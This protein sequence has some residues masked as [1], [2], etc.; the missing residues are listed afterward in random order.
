M[1]R[2]FSTA[3][4][5]DAAGRPGRS[6]GG[7]AALPWVFALGTIAAQI[8]YPLVDGDW[9]RRVTL[10]SVVLF[11][12]ASVSHALVHR[13]LRWALTLVAVTAGGGLAAEAVGVRT[14]LP[15]GDY[16][17]SGSLGPQLFAV[18]VV[19]PLAWTMMAYPMFL[20][21]RRISSRWTAVIGGIGLAGWDVFLD[22]QMVAD[23]RWRWSDPTPG[24]PGVTDVPLTNLAGWLLVGILMM[25][26]LSVALPRDRA[27]ETVPALLLFWTYVG[28]II[29]NVFWFGADSV[30][31]AGALAMGLV[32]IPYAWVL[33][34]SRP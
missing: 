1:N 3:P 2:G 11:F 18:P 24:L 16:T 4:A 15:F 19:V 12:L 29:G 14:G 13:G 34:S 28:S 26:L 22:P 25:G 27:S 17:Y 5:Y 23:G 32:A 7:A 8:A 21:A 10:A 30:A 31:M 9:L 20:A 6:S 33:W